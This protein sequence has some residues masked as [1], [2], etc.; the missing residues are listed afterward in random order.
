LLEETQ[1]KSCNPN[2]AKPETA[3]TNGNLIGYIKYPFQRIGKKA[4]FA[5]TYYVTNLAWTGRGAKD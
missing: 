2:S 4:C 3:K 5:L 1:R